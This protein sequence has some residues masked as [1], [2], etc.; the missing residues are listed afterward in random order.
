MLWHSNPYRAQS[1]QDISLAAQG[2]IS[3]NLD[4]QSAGLTSS[5]MIDGTVYAMLVPLRAGDVVTNISLI[6]NGPAG[7][8][9]TASK[10][11]LYSLAGTLLA[12]SADQGTAWQSVGTKTVALASPYTVPATGGY[13]AAL[14]AKATTTLPKPFCGA[15]S[16]SQINGAAIGSG[17]HPS[18]IMASQTD[19]PATAT[20]T[21]TAS[22][23]SYWV[24]IS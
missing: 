12:S 2:L 20:F 21:F 4:R 16:A 23:I 17:A 10:V 3:Q 19:L 9:V 8:D 14:F 1:L 5:T 11:G 24:G 15:G 13:Y 7:A 6:L 18:G 22:L